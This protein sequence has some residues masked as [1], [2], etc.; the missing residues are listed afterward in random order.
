MRELIEETLTIAPRRSSRPGSAARVT[1]TADITFSS[2]SDCHCSSSTS[3]TLP[4]VNIDG[5]PAPTLLTSRSMPPS[6]SSACR[7]ASSAP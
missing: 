7:T 5:S 6:R 1:R 3:S 4:R 2:H